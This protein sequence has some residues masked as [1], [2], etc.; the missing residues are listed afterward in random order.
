MYSLIHIV[1]EVKNEQ[2]RT[3]HATLRVEKNGQHLNSVALQDNSPSFPTRTEHEYSK[4]TNNDQAA[5]LCP[6][7]NLL[8]V[9]YRATP[10]QQA[11]GRSDV[12][13]VGQCR[14]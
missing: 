11:V 5:G 13:L 14:R 8:A 10:Q 1:S 12:T 2:A 3:Y 4:I 9:G 7:H 6:H